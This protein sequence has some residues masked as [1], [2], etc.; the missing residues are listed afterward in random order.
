MIVC[1]PGLHKRYANWQKH[2]VGG[3]IEIAINLRSPTGRARALQ[4]GKNEKKM[5]FRDRLIRERN[6]EGRLSRG[7]SVN[8]VI[9]LVE[10][11][12][13]LTHCWHTSNKFVFVL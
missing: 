9:V 1:F 6:R 11:P 8:I 2:Q 5:F 3:I 10:N 13:T 12:A 7:F 4:D